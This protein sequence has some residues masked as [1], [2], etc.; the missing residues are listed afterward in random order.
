MGQRDVPRVGRG[1]NAEHG[2]LWLAPCLPKLAH[3]TKIVRAPRQ[4]CGRGRYQL[5]GTIVL[6]TWYHRHHGDDG[7]ARQPATRASITLTMVMRPASASQLATMVMTTMVMTVPR[8]ASAWG[9]C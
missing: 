2:T 1:T 8:S 7:T 4:S 5:H 6:R 3:S 9:R